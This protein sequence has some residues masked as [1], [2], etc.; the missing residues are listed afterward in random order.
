M[1]KGI[2][3]VVAA[4]LLLVVAV[5]V[6]LSFQNWNKYYM[7]D[8]LTSIETSREIQSSI[9][10]DKIIG[11]KLYIKS[12]SPDNI[13]SFKIKISGKICNVTDNLSQGINEIDISDC[14]ENLSNSVVDI[15]IVTGDKIKQ[16][17][18]YLD[19]TNE[20]VNVLSAPSVLAKRNV[21]SLFQLQN[22]NFS[23]GYNSVYSQNKVYVSAYDGDIAMSADIMTNYNISGMNT[24]YVIKYDINS[25]N[26]DWIFQPENLSANINMVPL[27]TILDESGNVLVFFKSKG[28]FTIGSYDIVSDKQDLFYLKLSPTKQVL[29]LTK[30]ASV[31]YSGCFYEFDILKQ[32]RL[33]YAKSNNKYVTFKIAGTCNIDFFNTTINNDIDGVRFLAKF[34]SGDN[35]KWVATRNTTNLL[36]QN[37]ITTMTADNG[38]SLYVAVEEPD[39]GFPNTIVKF[40]SNGDVI[41]KINGSCVIHTIEVIDNNMYIRAAVSNSDICYVAGKMFT[42]TTLNALF[43]KY[44]LSFNYLSSLV[45][46]INMYTKKGIIQNENYLY[47]PVFKKES[48]DLGNNLTIGDGSM[49]MYLLATDLDLNLKQVSPIA[50]LLTEDAMTMLISTSFFDFDN[51]NNFYFGGIGPNMIYTFD[52]G[53]TLDEGLG[54][55]FVAKYE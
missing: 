9:G 47:T 35:L 11:D 30:I 8:V 5:F 20:E 50:N 41:E 53:L 15:V 17:K 29:S 12:L 26:I 49:K 18:L 7:S 25:N 36:F 54:N 51:S 38:E 21:T 52:N 1:K 2:S 46:P 23:S 24:F 27:E 16:K 40:D 32:T 10:I 31:E 33:F 13:S 6:V 4:S 3:S 55:F 34:D 45:V 14:L 37:D 42:N 19:D 28:N 22:M 44:D 48:F 43:L 39:A